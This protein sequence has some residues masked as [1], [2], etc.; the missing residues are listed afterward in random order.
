MVTTED[1]GMLQ[2]KGQASE[3]PRS[4]CVEKI[5][6]W[7]V[8]MTIF[9]N[10]A[11]LS[12]PNERGSRVVLHTQDRVRRAVFNALIGFVVTTRTAELWRLEW[13]RNSGLNP[14][15][16]FLENQKVFAIAVLMLSCKK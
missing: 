16:F 7:K 15:P 12:R 1:A 8:K 5:P 14:S 3:S 13:R 4:P 9:L 2:L 6:F 11:G 10:F